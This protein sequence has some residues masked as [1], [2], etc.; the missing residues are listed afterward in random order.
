MEHMPGDGIAS[1]TTQMRARASRTGALAS[2]FEIVPVL[3]KSSVLCCGWHCAA[4]EQR[5]ASEM[6]SHRAQHKCVH[7]SVALTRVTRPA[8][9]TRTTGRPDVTVLAASVPDQAC[10]LTA[11]TLPCAYAENS[12]RGHDTHV[13]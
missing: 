9:R 3:E 7:K 2:V 6:A 1:C 4:M 13:R 11:G 8:R 12:T 10:A 5:Q